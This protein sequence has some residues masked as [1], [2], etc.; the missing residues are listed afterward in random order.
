LN[1][2]LGNCDSPILTESINR[3]NRTIQLLPFHTHNGCKPPGLKR[4][5]GYNPA[6]NPTQKNEKNNKKNKIHFAQKR[7]SIFKNCIQ[8][9]DRNHCKNRVPNYLTLANIQSNLIIVY[10]SV[11]SY[12]LVNF[13]PKIHFSFKK[14][15]NFSFYKFKS[16]PVLTPNEFIHYQRG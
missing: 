12:H 6:K 8:K 14:I 15:N 7:D 4:N 2:C 1:L 11:I 16:R 13:Y 9:Q 5:S 3:I 10:N